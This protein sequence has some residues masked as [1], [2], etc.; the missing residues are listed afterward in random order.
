[1]IGIMPGQTRFLVSVRSAQ[2]AVI[3]LAGGA[4]IIDAKEPAEGALGAVPMAELGAI[5]RAVAGRR[6][7][8]ATIGDC[9]LDEAADRVATTAATG[10]DYVKIGLFG[11][12]S[13]I[14]LARLNHLAARGT[15]LIAVLFAD[16]APQWELIPRLAALRFSGVMLDTARKGDG[17]LR[18]HMDESD[19][20]RFLA[21]ARAHGLLAGLAG[22]LA[23]KD[24]AALLPLQPDVLGFRGALCSGAS[25]T[26][27]LDGGRVR[28]MRALISQGPDVNDADGRLA[29]AEEG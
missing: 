10:V 18:A 9:A 28:A 2:E 12:A 1:M 5:V 8:S 17:G 16:C 23:R 15:R 4:D 22:S 11:D 29:M 25:R 3:A 27:S 13:T 14:A 26:Q 7:I 19:L 6:P 21:E 20:A 24:A